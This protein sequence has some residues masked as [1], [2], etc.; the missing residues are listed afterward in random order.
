MKKL[1]IDVKGIQLTNLGSKMMLLAVME[2]MNSRF[3]C[4]FVIQSNQHNQH[5]ERAKL[6]LKQKLWF[7]RFG[8]PIAIYVDRLIPKKL[9]D[10]LGM[11]T[12]SEI[13][14]VLDCSGYAYNDAW[15]GDEPVKLSR[16]FNAVRGHGGK[17]VVMPQAF[18]PLEKSKSQLGLRKLRKSSNLFYS[19][20]SFSTKILHQAKITDFSQIPDFTN[21]MKSQRVPGYEDAI[22]FVPNTRMLSSKFPSYLPLVTRLKKV[23]D[24]LNK[25]LICLTHE[26]GEDLQFKKLF[27][28]QNLE[29]IEEIDVHH[30]K[31]I[32]SSCFG[33]VSS[34]FHAIVSALNGNTPCL[35]TSWSHKYEALYEEYELDGIITSPMDMEQKLLNMFVTNRAAAIEKV[36]KRNL[37]NMVATEGLFEEIIKCIEN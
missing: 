17:V 18:G 33:V 30:V 8:I 15:M 35:A 6:G 7:S 12:A 16:Y 13:D 23:C 11:V 14:L 20:D 22:I 5:K 3:D 31:S 25:N 34:R 29:I 24:S 32:L 9:R 28:D 21:W 26:V 4:E 37:K 1:M 19:R 2:K 27:A 10:Q 36:Q